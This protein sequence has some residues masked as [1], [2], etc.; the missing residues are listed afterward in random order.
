[1]IRMNFLE[2]I[3]IEMKHMIV[4]AATAVG[5]TYLTKGEIGPIQTLSDLWYLSFG[6]LHENVSDERKRREI[7]R[8]NIQVSETAKLTAKEVAL[9]SEDNLHEPRENIA[10]P[11][12]SA[13][14]DYS[15]EEHTR[16]M[17]SKLLASSMDASKDEISQQS[18]VEIVK[19]MSPL[20]AQNLKIINEY[21]SL[22]I[23]EVRVNTNSHGFFTHQTNIFLENM[24]N[25]NVRMNASSISNL[26]RLGLVDV[27]YQLKKNNSDV[28]LKFENTDVYIS[29]SQ[30]VAQDKLKWDAFSDE[31]QA[32]AM[33]KIVKYTNVDIAPGLVSITPLGQDF[34]SICLSIS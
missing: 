28:Y 7:I 34:C 18:F 16:E 11:V 13:M 6:N 10:R 8:Q 24:F 22:P 12:L 32:L 20:D 4:S 29:S 9:I 27:N 5:T 19:N 30:M 33:D 31:E 26:S 23:A 25:Q 21:E 1:M 14:N 3:P 2:S 17:F 15:S